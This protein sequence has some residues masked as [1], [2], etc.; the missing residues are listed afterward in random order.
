MT[1]IFKLST[2]LLPV[3][4]ITILLTILGRLPLY[5]GPTPVQPPSGI[6][7]WWSLDETNGSTAADRLGKFPA[8][9]ANGPVP[10]AG[11]VRGA[12]RFNGNNYLSVQDSD[13]WAF[14]TNNFSIELW[15]NFDRAPGGSIGEPSDIFIGNDEGPGSRNKWFFAVGGGYLNFHINS[16]TIGPQ[17]F[18]L[19]PFSPTVGQWYHLA[20]VRSGSTYTIYINGVAS[21]YATNTN[22]IPNPNAPLTIGQAE[23]L[24]F[25]QS[26]LDE[27]TIYNR[28]LTSAEVK[29]IYDAGSAGKGINLTILPNHGGDT[30]NVTC[31]INGTGFAQGATVMLA[32]IGQQTISGTNVAVGS[33]G[34]TIATTFN[35][36]GMTDGAWDVVVTNPSGTTFTLPA[37]FTIEPSN[38][39]QVSVNIV[40]L[41]LIRPG[42]AQSFN[43][44]YSNRGNVDV[45]CVPIW[46]SGIPTDATV[47]FGFN[48]TPPPV[49]PGEP[50]IDLS[51]APVIFNTGSELAIPLLIGGIPAG[52]SGTLEI[53]VT[54][55]TLESFQITAWCN[56]PYFQYGTAVTPMAP[57]VAGLTQSPNNLPPLNVNAA[58]CFFCAIGILGN[59]IP[60]P[61]CVQQ[62]SQYAISIF[63][64]IGSGNA[65]NIY[66][67]GQA[68]FKITRTLGTCTEMFV[69][70]ATLV[71]EFIN[72][73][74]NG[75]NWSKCGVSCGTAWGQVLP[76]SLP[77]QGI[78]SF[79]PNEKTGPQGT[80]QL[81]Y[82]SGLFPIPYSIFFQNLE[83]ATA[84][85]QQVV[86]TD[87]L[88]PTKVD[89][90]TFSF[91]PIAFGS[92]VVTPQAGQSSFTSDVDLRPSTDLIVRLTA[93]LNPNTAL[94]TWSYTSIDPATG[95]LPTDP[96]VGFLPPDVTPPQ[97]E[98]SVLFTVTP[99]QGLATGV[100]LTN[101]ATIVFDANS[102]LTT[103]TWTNTIDNSAPRSSVMSLPNVTTN[104]NLLVCWSGTDIGS[105]IADYDVY[106]ATNGGPWNLWLAGT[107]NICFA[108][109]GQ[110]TNGYGFYSVASDFT[111]NRETSHLTADTI[112]K[113]VP[114]VIAGTDLLGTMQN[115]SVA[116]PTLK[117][118][119]NDIDSAGLSLTITNVSATSTNGGSVLL[120][121]SFVTYTPPSGYAGT[122]AFLYTAADS[123]GGSGQGTVIVTIAPSNQQSLNIIS[124]TTTAAGTTLVFAG[125][126]GRFYIVQSA[127]AV[128][129]P[130][131]NLSGSLTADS[132]GLIQF[133]DTTT[134][135]PARFYRTI[136]N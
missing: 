123:F 19:V 102:P 105:G 112:T 8:A 80:G 31:T 75:Y 72:A 16:P 65:R 15:V 88:D 89:L 24:G 90:S 7:A 12:L 29:S 41:P 83:T 37:G 120:N 66:S 70:E 94:V 60:G 63:T 92:N 74:L 46:I 121:G 17:F 73:V 79:D 124:I 107:T 38:S 18:P 34:T 59:F 9:Y 52:Q 23:Q 55:P 118:L 108:F 51:Q 30:G 36:T 133:T 81:R 27:I 98:G 131:T 111:G 6:I 76:V 87:Q 95:N 53:R 40:G 2:L 127:P 32:R 86:I 50:A 97:G 106:V 122:D 57:I 20:V 45:Y 136:G 84:P 71:I 134:L 78:A 116:A 135:P 58:N 21:G 114:M 62:V 132:T 3:F 96:R 129:G 110:V 39:S 35:L 130:W 113:I 125:I 25:T 119:A 85:A 14:G 128:G 115:K 64:T 56:P 104:G 4:L 77:V 82:I 54:V 43:I 91:G 11:E 69:P 26:R 10:T 99:K 109:Q 100:S 33:A 117:L 93:S 13:S 101:R 67:V 28:A 22:V 47:T 61:A 5:A 68:F 49:I 126:P 44:V 103:G 48:I 42:R 1:K